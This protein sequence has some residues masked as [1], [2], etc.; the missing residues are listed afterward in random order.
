M[1]SGKGKGT[2]QHGSRFQPECKPA[3]DLPPLMGGMGAIFQAFPINRIHGV[4]S[5][6]ATAPLDSD[7]GTSRPISQLLTITRGRSAD[8]GAFQA[9]ALAAWRGGFPVAGRVSMHGKG[10]G[11]G[12]AW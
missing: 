11:K 1:E 6:G 12:M 9:V 3:C 10:S 4:T 2:N 8:L 7:I 5:D